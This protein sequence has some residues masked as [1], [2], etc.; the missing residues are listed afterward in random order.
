MPDA[1]TTS[2]R[3]K[4]VSMAQAK[5]IPDGY[6]AIIPQLVVSDAA[7]AI[8]WYVKAFGAKEASRMAMPNG[9]IMHAEVRIGDSVFFLMDEMPGMGPPA[10]S[11]D[12]PSAASIMLYVNDCDGTYATAVREGA[13]TLMPVADQFWGD[14]GGMLLDPFGYPWFIGTHVKDMTVEEQRRAGEEW[15]R[16]QAASGGGAGAHP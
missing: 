8:A 14:R 13:R 11:P 3:T 6:H 7:K 10:P 1:S 4:E 16:S 5:P 12:R 15:M 2:A 9:K